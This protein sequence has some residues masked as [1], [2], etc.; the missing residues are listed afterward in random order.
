[1]ISE[2]FDNDFDGYFETTGF[3][4]DGDGRFD[5]I[6]TDTNLDGYWDTAWCDTDFNGSFNTVAVDTDGDGSMD[7]IAADADGD[8]IPET[9]VDIASIYTQNAAV[10]P[11]TSYVS[12]PTDPDPY[13][14]FLTSPAVVNNTDPYIQGLINDFQTSLEIQTSVWTLPDGWTIEREYR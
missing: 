8:G 12:A 4:T 3:D 9:P 10:Y 13:Y 7:W 6:M 11:S 14:T 2:I 5:V 1:M